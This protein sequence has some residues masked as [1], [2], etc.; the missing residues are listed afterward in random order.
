MASEKEYEG[1]AGE[2]LRDTLLTFPDFEIGINNVDPRR[3]GANNLLPKVFN[4]CGGT[5][6]DAYLILLNLE[7]QVL[8]IQKSTV[9]R[10]QQAEE[11]DRLLLE[12]DNSNHENLLVNEDEELRQL[13]RN[14]LHIRSTAREMK[15]PRFLP[16]HEECIPL[17][18]GKLPKDWIGS[19]NV[20]QI[21]FILAIPESETLV[22]TNACLKQS[23]KATIEELQRWIMQLLRILVL[24]EGQSFRSLAQ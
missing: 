23:A 10:T 20:S 4:I 14:E 12:W 18:R 11:I 3:Y 13:L 2:L 5:A 9:D 6:I 17:A 8:E 19:D 21:K 22:T 1:R 15:H 16:G 7:D 24:D